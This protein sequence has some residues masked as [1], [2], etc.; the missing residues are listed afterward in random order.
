MI[1]EIMN[2][3]Q[4]NGEEREWNIGAKWLRFSEVLALTSEYKADCMFT[5]RAMD[6]C[7]SAVS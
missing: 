4:R 3:E 2:G 7:Q 6:G 5:K 1:K